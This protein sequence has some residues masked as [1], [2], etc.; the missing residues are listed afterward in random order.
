[1]R[2]HQRRKDTQ[3]GTVDETVQAVLDFF[4]IHLVALQT[5]V[6]VIVVERF[7]HARVKEEQVAFEVQVKTAEVHVGGTDDAV[8]V[9]ADD[10]FRVNEPGGVAIDF[11]PFFYEL[12]IESLGYSEDIFFVGNVRHCDAHV[13]ARAGGRDQRALHFAVENEV[14]GIDINV[15]FRV[16]DDFEVHVFAD[17]GILTVRSVAERDAGAVAFRLVGE[18][19]VEILVFV[20]QGPQLQEQGREVLN[21]AAAHENARIL[22]MAE[23]VRDVDVF[24]REVDAARERSLAVDDGDFA[25]GAVVL[26]D[27]DDGTEGVKAHAFDSALFENF[28]VVSGHFEHG[29]DIVV[30]EAHVDAVCGFFFQD[31][32]HAVEKL[33]WFDDEILQKDIFFRFLQ[34][35]QQLSGVRFAVGEIAV[36]GAIGEGHA[37]MD[38][39]IFGALNG[40]RVVADEF[41][42]RAFLFGVRVE[43]SGAAETCGEDE[44][45]AAGQFMSAQQKIK[46]DSD[47]RQE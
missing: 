44:S 21:D 5:G 6:E 35:F 42:V 19:A 41:A 7:A 18:V 47:G 24:V 36:V 45:S 13:H 33:A 31:F 30:D 23:G 2:S 43:A 22:P 9:V 17:V 29:A 28:G 32:Q 15:F 34:F 20:A 40:E 8:F 12:G 39:D 11:D 16:V 14:R 46:Q 27:V 37:R 3:N 1:M 38:G 26:G 25:V 10:A 4:D